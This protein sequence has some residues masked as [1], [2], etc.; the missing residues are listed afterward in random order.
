MKEATETRG[1]KCTESD[2]RRYVRLLFTRELAFP[3][4][5]KVWD[6]LFA[7]DPD[8]TGMV[9]A[10]AVALL[11]RIRT[12]SERCP[13]YICDSGADTLEIQF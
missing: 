9:E 3:A 5:L 12:L 1:I 10:M 4:A 2:P 13:Q 7:L 6:G 11:L 8:L